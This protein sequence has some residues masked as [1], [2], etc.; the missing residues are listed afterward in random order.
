MQFRYALDYESVKSMLARFESSQPLEFS[1]VELTAALVLGDIGHTIN[2]LNRDFTS[3]KLLRLPTAKFV[4]FDVDRRVFVAESV[5]LGAD[6]FADY[7]VARV[8]NYMLQVGMP[9]INAGQISEALGQHRNQLEDAVRIG[10]SSYIR[11]LK[12]FRTLPLE[13]GDFEYRLG[14]FTVGLLDG[15]ARMI[16]GR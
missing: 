3:G 2:M 13:K 11:V 9:S 14:N 15:V 8:G 12:Q 16:S 1:P 10:L 5:H 6:E 4:S 7:N